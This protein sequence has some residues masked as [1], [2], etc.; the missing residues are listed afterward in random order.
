M[1]ARFG[2]G[3]S[4]ASSSAAS[5]TPTRRALFWS[6]DGLSADSSATSCGCSD[7]GCASLATDGG[8]ERSSAG[9]GSGGVPSARPSGRCPAA[10][11]GSGCGSGLG[12]RARAEKA[13]RA[14]AF[15]EAKAEL[16]ERRA[17]ASGVT[18]CRPAALGS[19][20]ASRSRFATSA[21]IVRRAA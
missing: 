3:L 11:S 4:V 20:P 5:S 8:A 6:S 1:M 13:T 10:A 14:G 17:S 18:P 16:R 9:A 15:Q 21:C 19:P 7:G 2:C 12:E